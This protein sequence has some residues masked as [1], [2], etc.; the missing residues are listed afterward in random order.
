VAPVFIQA[1]GEDAARPSAETGLL[2]LGQ[3]AL[4]RLIR[5]AT[6]PWPS[7]DDESDGSRRKRRSA[8]GLI[9]QIGCPSDA[10]P[11]LR[12]LMD[13]KD[14]RISAFAC[15]LGLMQGSAA[16]R[17]AAAGHLAEL[18]AGADWLLRSDIHDMLVECENFAVDHTRRRALDRDRAEGQASLK[19]K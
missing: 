11:R 14:A 7:A 15:R 2:R 4:P 18:L 13:D 19:G 10:W 3:L 6:E 12:R 5:A 17:K 16:D 1:L 9:L 8:L